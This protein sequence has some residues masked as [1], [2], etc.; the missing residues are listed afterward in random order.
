MFLGR[1]LY[2]DGFVCEYTHD[3]VWYHWYIRIRAQRAVPRCDRERSY[4]R[5]GCELPSHRDA[6]A[7]DA[8]AKEDSMTFILGFVAGVAATLVCQA[9]LRGIF[10]N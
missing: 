10:E 1:R 2:G 9:I 4:D 7:W 8:L 6:K 3:H 5:G